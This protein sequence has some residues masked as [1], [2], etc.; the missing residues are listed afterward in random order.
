MANL[1][2]D[3]ILDFLRKLRVP[4]GLPAGVEGLLPW[5]DPEVMRL[6]AAFYRKFY[7][8]AG[9]RTLIL[10]I[11][12]G[13]FGGGH[14]GIPFTDPIRLEQVC[15]IPNELN[16]RAELS[17]DFVYRV[18]SAY[19]GPGKFYAKFF[20]SSVSPVGYVQ[21]GTN[22]NYY[23]RPDLKGL[24]SEKAPG[25]LEKQLAFGL[26]RKVCFCFGEGKNLDFLREMNGRKGYFGEI[27]GLP[28]PRFVMQYRRKQLD[29][30]ISRYV[31]ALD[32][33]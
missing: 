2:D 12:P 14:T 18:I 16:K 5:T 24:I 21:N 6:C 17:S 31:T 25:W 7:H 32:A 28:H 27:I 15:G 30:F 13:R 20:I 1:L 26:D 33:A 11:N 22:L 8:D 9:P 23:D 3:E 10:G 19:G 29:D 4:L